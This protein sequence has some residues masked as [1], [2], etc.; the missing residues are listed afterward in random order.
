MQPV[1]LTVYDAEDGT[2]F[3]TAT[4]CEHYE[5]DVRLVEG[6][7]QRLGIPRPR[8]NAPG[9]DYNGKTF[10]RVKVGTRDLAWKAARDE[11]W[12]N[13]RDAP[14]PWNTLYYDIQCIDATGRMWGQPYF[15]NNPNPEAR[16]VFLP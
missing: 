10:L 12:P 11:A 6:I 14:K 13:P 1:Q 7:R 2:R 3:T 4:A 5:L 9:W 15:A 16:E 8:D